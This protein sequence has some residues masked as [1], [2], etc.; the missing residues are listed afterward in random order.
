MML[1]LSNRCELCGWGLI[2]DVPV[3]VNDL[4]ISVDFAV[5]TIPGDEEIPLIFGK[6]FL[7]ASRALI[8]DEEKELV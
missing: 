2:R 7:A 4:L 8:P 5:V 3:K 6:P 1:T